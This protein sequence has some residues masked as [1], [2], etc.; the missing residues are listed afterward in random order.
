MAAAGL[1]WPAKAATATIPIVF[2]FGDGDP[3]KHGLVETFNRPGGNVNGITMIAGALELKRFELL[4][5]IVPEATVIHKVVNPNNVG[6]VQDI[7]EIAVAA[8]GIGLALEV[9]PAG[10]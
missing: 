10:Y 3:V 7:P 4:R 6:V 1:R 2:T 9:M 8:R 5:E